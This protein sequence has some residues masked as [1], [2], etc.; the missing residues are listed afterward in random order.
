MRSQFPINAKNNG[1]HL[2][3]YN[4]GEV[5]NSLHS[6]KQSGLFLGYFNRQY[7][8]LKRNEI[9]I[10]AGKARVKQTRYNVV[11]CSFIT[12]MGTV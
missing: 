8:T 10:R 12:V 3:R 6:F 7:K 11:P 9:S 5:P 2:F 4:S 1:K